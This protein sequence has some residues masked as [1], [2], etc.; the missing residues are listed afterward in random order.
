M[1]P[2]STNP[3]SFAR[4]I[5][6]AY[7]RTAIL[8]VVAIQIVSLS[9]YF[10]AI[11]WLQTTMS[12]YMRIAVDNQITRLCG[13]EASAIDRQLGSVTYE[14]KL[15]AEEIKEA[16]QTSAALSP[17]DEARLRYSADGAYYTAA[18]SGGAA[19]FYSGYV[20]VGE[21]ERQKTARVLTAQGLM[22]NIYNTNPLVS[23]IYFN[24]FDSLNIIY[25]YFDV[26]SQYMI[27]MNIPSFNFYYDADT[28]HNPGQHQLW[29]DVYLD[30]AGHGWMASSIAPV[31]TGDVLQGVVG[32]DVTV[33]NI[34]DQ[35]L[36]MEMPGNGYGMLVGA[37]GM[38]LALPEQGE[39]DWGLTELKGH[40]YSEAVKQDTFKPEAFNLSKMP[41]LSEFT[42]KL[43]ASTS[44]QVDV[45]IGGGQKIVSWATIPQTG[46]KLIVVIPQSSVFDK[47]NEVVKTMTQTGF[48]MAT[49]MLLLFVLF[50]LSLSLR[51][52]KMS[53]DISLPLVE[54]DRMVHDIGEGDYYQKPRAFEVLELQATA[55]NVVSMGNRLGEVNRT[56]LAAQEAA[57]AASRAKSLFLSNMSH[58][59]RTPLNAVLGFAQVLEMDQAAPLTGLQ[60]EC[61]EEITKA[62]N[63]L[64]EL[65]NEVL[66]LAR[67][68][69]GKTRL[70]IEPVE[71]KG[72]L[73]DALAMIIPIA[74]AHGI[75]LEVAEELHVG[76][77]ILADK[78]KFKQIL[79]NLLSNAVKYNKPGGKVTLSCVEQD[80]W[81]HFHVTDTGIGI[82]Q[83]ELEEIFK[84]FHRLNNTRNIVEGTG[85]GLA[86]VKQLVEMMSG[87]VH[88]DSVEGEG[89]HFVVT[90]PAAETE[91]LLDTTA[92][93]LLK[94]LAPN[95]VTD[96]KI[97]Y[98]ED[99]PANLRV[100][101]R[102][103]ELMPNIAFL[104]AQSGEEGVLLAMRELPD[105]I[106]LDINLPGMDGYETF[107]K[108][109]ENEKT[110][111]IPVI[112]VSSNAMEREIGH[113]MRM[114]FFDYV[115]KPI[116]A[117]M[118]FDRL[119]R[120]FDKEQK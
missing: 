58:E 92:A 36:K 31:Y 94:P 41:T 1:G 59:L 120:V 51:S 10:G 17:A 97:L 69:A 55:G 21:A 45:T 89:S 100:V 81:V 48:I 34:T 67:I 65:I 78:I 14:T 49:L 8:P 42:A 103:L 44:G 99:N 101:E 9:I 47:V 12:D 64:L 117:E 32:I 11:G 86:V 54:L 118:F 102:M 112:A 113:A 52:K 40:H 110:R 104:S 38:I 4:W 76:G 2:T 111:D 18:D 24:T 73:E 88:V 115:T 13:V 43:A 57:E 30:P 90:V 33:S 79:I 84:P 15:Y 75:K 108:F 105:V 56:L 27:K 87:S 71:I 46:W 53:R 63:H 61:I 60:K 6:R 50:F 70:S 20:P 106:L 96:K 116:K 28:A 91:Q 66:D 39:A 82:P 83:Q 19:V 85:V 5:W 26:I 107:M 95:I 35:L 114:G 16:L 119:K 7:F 23:S 68:E 80:G 74:E 72:V 93:N 25:P 37:D 62:G 98:I 3:I 109:H 22:K 77:Y 29:T